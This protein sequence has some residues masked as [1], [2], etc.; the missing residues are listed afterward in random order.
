MGSGKTTVG[1]RLAER[2]GVAVRGPRRRDREDLRRDGPGPVRDLRR[3]GLSRAGVA[4]PRGH[5]IASA[6]GR[7]DGRRLLRSRG[8]RRTIAAWALPSFSTCRSRSCAPASA[9]RPTA[10]SSRT[11]GRPRALFAER[12]PFYRMG[13][14]RVRS[15][16]DE[17][18]E[19]AADRVLDALSTRSRG[20]SILEPMRY[21][22]LSDIHSNDE[23]LA[24]VLA[25]RRGGEDSTGSSSSAISSA[26]ARSPT[27]SG[28][29]R[30]A[31]GSARS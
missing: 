11:R 13:S 9:E 21:L 27:R 7:R 10:R 30:A 2:L 23:A 22:L 24:A 20:E 12:E 16:G 1:R 19:E 5:G 8:N 26:T 31:S 28:P 14:V 29:A 18:I 6:R 25:T 4:L 17:P 15:G 3:G